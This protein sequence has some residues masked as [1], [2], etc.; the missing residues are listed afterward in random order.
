MARKE[1]EGSEKKD[2]EE[3]EQSEESD[4]VD[5][6]SEDSEEFDEAEEE[7]EE[8]RDR[9]EE[10]ELLLAEKRPEFSPAARWAGWILGGLVGAVS[11]ALVVMMLGGGFPTECE[12][13]QEAG[14][15]PEAN[16]EAE[17]RQALMRLIQARGQELQ[18]CFDDWAT[19]NPEEARPGRVILIS[20]L[21]EANEEG[22][23]QEATVTGRDVPEEFSSCL[24]SRI[25]NWEFPTAGPIQLELP[26][27]V[28]D[29]A[30]P[31][32]NKGTD[33]APATD[34]ASEPDEQ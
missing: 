32:P 12:C 14:E 9:V 8:L 26:F 5:E 17:L 11:L 27:A 25:R 2:R 10:L 1:K 30:G 19:N 7:L 33:A 29:N 34:A 22:V 18:Q 28:E 21:V 6:I 24:E 13:D 15:V 4:E 16:N 3:N 23:V 31:T 20:L